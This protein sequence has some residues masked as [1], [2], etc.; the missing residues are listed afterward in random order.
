MHKLKEKLMEELYELEER[1]GKASGKM[2]SSDLEM[3]H[4]LTDTVKN[5]DKIEMLEEGGGYSEESNW[6]ADGRMYGT[7]YEGGSSY[8]RGDG[9]GR[10]RNA[11]RDSMGR[12]SVYLGKCEFH[13]KTK[14]SPLDEFYEGYV[15][16]PLYYSDAY[17]DF[18]SK[19]LSSDLKTYLYY[20]SNTPVKFQIHGFDILKVKSKKFVKKIGNIKDISKLDGLNLLVH[21]S[22]NTKTFDEYF[23]LNLLEK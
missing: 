8:R 18:V 5:I 2:S 22:Y 23:R 17:T 16:R 19:L 6:M 9:R 14:N 13:N 15:Y 3:V 20:D 1:L 11:R 10:G 12:Y 4:K 7:S 21:L